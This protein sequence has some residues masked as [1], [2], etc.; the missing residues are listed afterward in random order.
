MLTVVI[1]ITVRV[2]TITGLTLD[3]VNFIKSNRVTT[4]ADME[5]MTARHR[6][7]RAVTLSSAEETLIVDKHNTLRKQEGASDMEQLVS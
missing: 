7:R 2:D 1:A 4:L 3:R 5:K 6:S